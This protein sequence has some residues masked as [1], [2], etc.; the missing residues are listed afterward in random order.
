MYCCGVT[1]GSTK[2]PLTVQDMSV[3]LI[4]DEQFKRF[5]TLLHSK[6][7]NKD[8]SVHATV[9]GRI[10]V[11]PYNIAQ[12]HRWGYGHM[13]CCVLIAVEQVL[14]VDSKKAGPSIFDL[15]KKYEAQKK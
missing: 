6:N 10:F 8:I 1:P 11:A 12:L 9:R 5:D 7:P 4:A 15:A 2:K 3:P 14:S 13:G